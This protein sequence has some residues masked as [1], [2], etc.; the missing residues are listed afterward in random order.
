MGRSVQADAD[1]MVASAWDQLGEIR[2]ANQLLR[3]A[4]F[5]REVTSSMNQRHLQK[6]NGD[7]VYLQR[8]PAPS[9][10]GSA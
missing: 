7:G 8:S 10:E 1:A 9:T 2:K 4:Q 5:A 6:V 3:Q